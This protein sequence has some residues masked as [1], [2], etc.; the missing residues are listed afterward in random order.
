MSLLSVDHISVRISLELGKVVIER[1]TSFFLKA[2]RE[3]DRLSDGV[4]FGD[5]SDGNTPVVESRVEEVLLL[6]FLRSNQEHVEVIVSLLHHSFPVAVVVVI[7]MP[8]EAPVENFRLDLLF[9]GVIRFLF[10][11]LCEL[12]R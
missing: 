4:R 8:Q 11:S 2:S 3:R 1:T 9:S 5:D 6:V 10:S 7:L 12:F